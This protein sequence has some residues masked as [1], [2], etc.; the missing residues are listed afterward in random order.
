M[1]WHSTLYKS[2]WGH[3]SGLGPFSPPLLPASQ[4]RLSA[5]VNLEVHSLRLLVGS[6]EPSN[7][8]V[9]QVSISLAKCWIPRSTHCPC[10][11]FLAFHYHIH[12]LSPSCHCVFIPQHSNVHQNAQL[13]YCSLFGM[14]LLLMALKQCSSASH[15]LSLSR[16]L[17]ASFKAYSHIKP[18][19]IPCVHLFFCESPCGLCLGAKN[20]SLFFQRFDRGDV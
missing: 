8:S 11:P 9:S 14:L 20:L 16:G 6:A 10:S 19:F 15:S 12:S 17:S 18:W 7:L 1:Y 2:F 3:H 4:L 13:K 5:V